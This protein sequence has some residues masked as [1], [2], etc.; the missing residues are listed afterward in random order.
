MD[1]S[2]WWAQRLSRT[3]AAIVALN[4]GCGCR[5]RRFNMWLPSVHTAA[6]VSLLAVLADAQGTNNLVSH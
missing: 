2:F 6:T 3:V 4:H 5:L 1:C